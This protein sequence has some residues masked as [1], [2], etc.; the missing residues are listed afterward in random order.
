MPRY[1]RDSHDPADSTNSSYFV[2]T[3][4]KTIFAG[5]EGINMRQIT[6]GTAVTFLVVEAQRDIPWAKPEDIPYLADKPVLALGGRYA[7]GYLAAFCD[8]S[9]R[10]IADR[11]DEQVLR[12]LIMP[13]D[14]IPVPANLEFSPIEVFERP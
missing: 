11:I 13:S 6:D 7:G 2:L 10:F 3:G 8:G 9:V 12:T 1:F 14:G 4:P 5:K